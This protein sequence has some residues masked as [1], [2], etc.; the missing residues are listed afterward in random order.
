MLAEAGKYSLEIYVKLID[1]YDLYL[2]IDETI[3]YFTEKAGKGDV[4]L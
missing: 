2:M 1:G 4:G 3:Q